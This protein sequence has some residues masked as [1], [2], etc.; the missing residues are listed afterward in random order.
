MNGTALPVQVNVRFLMSSNARPLPCWSQVMMK[1]PSWRLRHGLQ[2]AIRA[3]VSGSFLFVKSTPAYTQPADSPLC[4][5]SIEM[6]PL[7]VFESGRFQA[8]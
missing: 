8:K 1:S 2:F 4:W 3:A 5:N 6:N 7:P